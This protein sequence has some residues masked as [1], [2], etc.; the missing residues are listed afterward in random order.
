METV[1]EM[2]IFMKI[3]SLLSFRIIVCTHCV[4]SLCVLIVC[5][6]CVYSLCVLISDIP[7]TELNYKMNLYELHP[8]SRLLLEKLTGPQRGMK[9]LAFV[10][11]TSPPDPTLSQINPFHAPIPLLEDPF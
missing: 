5:T 1:C 6:H 11:K 4:Y 8:W 2:L 9:F 3:L 10:C 7:L